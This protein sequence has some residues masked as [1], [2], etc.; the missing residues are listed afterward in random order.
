MKVYRSWPKNPPHSRNHVEDNIPRIYIDN[1]DLLD[2]PDDLPDNGFILLEWDIAVSPEDLE[3]FWHHA[4]SVS[5]RVLVAPYRLYPVSTG[6]EH[7]VWAHR[8]ADDP[9][10]WIEYSERW[11]DYFSLGMVY[12]PPGVISRYAR[13]NQRMTDTMFASWYRK[14]YD[15]QTY[16]DWSVH[17]VHL[18]Y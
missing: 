13:T 17:P 1:Y 4:R 15:V 3:A 7:P 16:V 5:T 10:R 18:H 9:E 8:V 14:T 2:S 11:C 6:L 12:L